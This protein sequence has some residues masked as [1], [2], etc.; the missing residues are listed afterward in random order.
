MAYGLLANLVL[1]LHLAFLLFVVLGGLLVFRWPRVAWVHV[2]CALWGMLTEFAGIV[3]PLTPLENVLRHR[4]GEAGYSGDFI[5][6]YITAALYPA[7]LSRGVQLAL[8]AFALAVNMVIYGRVLARRAR[9]RA[10]QLE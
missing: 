2:P 7:G 4:A 3:C 9:H 8:G 1:L 5:A 10:G 6:H